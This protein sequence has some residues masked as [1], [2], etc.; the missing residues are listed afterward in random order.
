VAPPIRNRRAVIDFDGT[1]SARGA[2][3]RKHR[4]KASY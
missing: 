4:R 3:P 1:E 2:K